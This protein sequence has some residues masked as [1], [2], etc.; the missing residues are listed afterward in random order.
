TRS[1]LEILADIHR[2]V[3][4]T[5]ALSLSRGHFQYT[6]QNGVVIVKGHIS[7]RI[8]YELFV[9]NLMNIDGVVAVDDR[10]L[11]DDETLR[12][13]IGRILPKGLRVRIHHGVVALSGRMAADS[14][15]VQEAIARIGE[16]PGV[17]NIDLSGLH[18]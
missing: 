15:E 17:V 6:V 1:D 10:E 9:D 14:P 12:L 13:N 3:Q 4:D 7:S 2:L 5:Q 11:Y 16:M 18:A 8:G